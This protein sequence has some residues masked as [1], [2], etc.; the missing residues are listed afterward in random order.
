MNCISVT[1]VEASKTSE[2]KCLKDASSDDGRSETG[3]QNG[4]ENSSNNSRQ[5]KNEDAQSSS[6]K[7]RTY[8]SCIFNFRKAFKK[9]FELNRPFAR[10]GRLLHRPPT[11]AS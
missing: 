10:L 9:D 4:S 2:G 1:V 5:I 8:F 7:V 3:S 11:Y 6:S